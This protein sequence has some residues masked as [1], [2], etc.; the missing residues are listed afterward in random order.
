[1]SVEQVAYLANVNGRTVRA[2]FSACDGVNFLLGYTDEGVY[3]ATECDDAVNAYTRRLKH[4]A[5]HM[6]DRVKRR[7]AMAAR[8]PLRGQLPLI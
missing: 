2:I 4:Q 5:Q 7:E 3:I 1:M 8:M 6:T